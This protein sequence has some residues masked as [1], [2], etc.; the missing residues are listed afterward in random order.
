[1]VTTGFTCSSS[2][3]VKEVIL[4]LLQRGTY[5]PSLLSPRGAYYPSLLSPRGEEYP[6]VTT[7]RRVPFCHHAAMTPSSS[8]C[9][10]DTVLLTMRRRELCPPHAAKRA[11]PSSCGDDTSPVHH[12]AMTPLLFINEAKR[13]HQSITVRSREGHRALPGTYSSVLHILLLKVLALSLKNC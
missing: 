13:A 1:M 7:R 5:Y 6:P 3:G 10:D 11:L 2:P 8:S 12:A 4:T 9:G